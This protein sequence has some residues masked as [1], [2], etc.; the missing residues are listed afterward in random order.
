[1]GN[2]LG[3]S[4]C[5]HSCYKIKI[6]IDFV[7]STCFNRLTAHTALALGSPLISLTLVLKPACRIIRFNSASFTSLP[8]YITPSLSS[9]ALALALAQKLVLALAQKP[10][11]KIIRLPRVSRSLATSLPVYITLNLTF[12]ALALAL[13]LNPVYRIIHLPRI[14]RSLASKK[15]SKLSPQATQP[16]TA[17][18]HYLSQTVCL[19][20]TDEATCPGWKETLLSMCFISLATESQQQTQPA[21][22]NPDYPCPALHPYQNYGNSI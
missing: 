14:S 11:Y 1:M 20:A 19:L 21:C 12:L 4:P 7:R 15:I 10:V 9:L 13:A 18:S 2:L 6:R 3:W 17:T 22:C 16:K 5:R 8:V